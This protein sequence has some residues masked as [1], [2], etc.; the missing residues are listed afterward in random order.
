MGPLDNR[1]SING[2]KDSLNKLTAQMPGLHR[3]LNPNPVIPLP[4][5]MTQNSERSNNGRNNKLAPLNGAPE[6]PDKNTN[7]LS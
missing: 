7:K 6:S 5:K 1:N 3:V 2:N 4:S